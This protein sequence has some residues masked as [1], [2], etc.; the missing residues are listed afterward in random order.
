[1]QAMVFCNRS[2]LIMNLAVL[3]SKNSALR[4][5]LS[6]YQALICFEF[7]IVNL[8][9]LALFCI[10]KSSCLHQKLYQITH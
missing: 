8:S 5:T 10:D 1:M 4:F 3:T 9:H 7:V 6:S 2:C